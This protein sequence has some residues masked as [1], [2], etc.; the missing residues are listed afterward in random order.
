MTNC[1]SFNEIFVAKLCQFRGNYTIKHLKKRH[2]CG[3]RV[4][5]EQENVAA[6]RLNITATEGKYRKKQEKGFNSSGITSKNRFIFVKS[7]VR[8]CK[9]FLFFGCFVFPYVLYLS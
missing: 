6:E 1:F 3:N 5:K 4:M 8:N 7:L 2:F 9:A